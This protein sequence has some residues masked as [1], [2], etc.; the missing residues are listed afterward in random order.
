ME[1]KQCHISDQLYGVPEESEQD[2][3]EYVGMIGSSVTELKGRLDLWAKYQD[4]C[5]K[6]NEKSFL[7]GVNKEELQQSGRIYEFFR[8]LAVCHTV[9]VDKEDGIQYQASSPDELAL[10]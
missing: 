10:I 6:K 2:I 5:N 8:M 9:V 3:T 1:F 4:A 7:N